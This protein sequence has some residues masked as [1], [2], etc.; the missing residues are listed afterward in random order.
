M[1]QCDE[2][3]KPYYG[4]N[5]S[6]LL[7]RGKCRDCLSAEDREE[8]RQTLLKYANVIEIERLIIDLKLTAIATKERELA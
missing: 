3:K 8:L 4:P 2:C 1:P 6:G 5:P 7:F